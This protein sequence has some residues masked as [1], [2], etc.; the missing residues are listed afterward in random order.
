MA[1]SNNDDV[2]KR[3]Q[4]QLERIIFLEMASKP[5]PVD[6]ASRPGPLPQPHVAIAPSADNLAQPESLNVPEDPPSYSGLY[7]EPPPLYYSGELPPAYQVAASLPTYEEAEL[8]K[9]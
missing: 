9:G 3:K 5:D 2:D 8:S 1:D 4:K 7:D 6:V